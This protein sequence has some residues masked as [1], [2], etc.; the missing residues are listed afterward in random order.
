[1]SDTA[2]RDHVWAATLRLLADREEIRAR[3]VENELSISASSRTV[4][5]TLRAMEELEWVERDAPGSH[6]WHAGPE[7][8]QLLEER[9]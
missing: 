4:R 6:Y 5:R 7:F 3:D 9:G 8:R 1:M 2:T